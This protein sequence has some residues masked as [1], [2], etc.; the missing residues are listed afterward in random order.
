ME[1]VRSPG[2]FEVFS[3]C[4]CWCLN[5][6]AL[7]CTEWDLNRFFGFRMVH[8]ALGPRGN[9]STV[10]SEPFLRR[11][12]RLSRWW[13]LHVRIAA[14]WL[15]LHVNSVANFQSHNNN[16]WVPGA[17]GQNVDLYF[18]AIHTMVFVTNFYVILFRDGSFWLR[19]R[20]WMIELIWVDSVLCGPVQNTGHAYGVLLKCN[21]CIEW[22]Y[23]NAMEIMLNIMVLQIISTLLFIDFS[24]SM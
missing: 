22:K 10:L 13:L 1:W 3:F 16:N 18:T 17:E 2:H 4:F 7:M 5:L 23:V 11:V 6:C 8:P 15:R 14:V 9:Q 12:A 19:W 21:I 24:T 20:P